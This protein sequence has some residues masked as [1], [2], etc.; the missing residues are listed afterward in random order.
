MVVHPFFESRPNILLE[1][2]Y[3]TVFYFLPITLSSYARAWKFILQE[4]NIE[5]FCSYSISTPE[6]FLKHFKDQMV[7]TIR[8]NSKN[9]RSNR[10]YLKKPVQC[11]ITETRIIQLNLISLCHLYQKRTGFLLQ[12]MYTNGFDI[13]WRHV[14]FQRPSLLYRTGC[15]LYQLLPVPG[16]GVSPRPVVLTLPDP[17]GEKW[18]L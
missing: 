1:V 13:V 4:S 9:K 15:G 5:I 18:W 16:G 14:T 2:L 11:L 7:H 6:A 17:S 3:C 10:F 8:V 12:R